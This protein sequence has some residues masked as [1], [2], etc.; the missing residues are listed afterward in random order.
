MRVAIVGGGVGGLTTCLALRA[1][2]IEA[3]V[4]EEVSQYKPVGAGILVAANGMQVLAQLGLAEAVEA[5]GFRVFRGHL[6]DPE[7][8]RICD[9][10]LPPNHSHSDRWRNVAIHRH[11]LM[12]VLSEALPAEAIQFGK[13]CVG[14]TDHDVAAEVRFAGGQCIEADL[15]VAADGL[16]SMQRSA[17]FPAATPR[18]AG[19]TSWRGYTDF[20]FREPILRDALLE[21]WGGDGTR[22]GFVPLLGGQTYWYAI[23]EASAREKDAPGATSDVLARTF[24]SYHPEILRLLAATPEPRVVRTDLYDL[25]RLPRW[26]AGRTVLLGDA[27]HGATPNLGQG[28]NQALEDAV[29]LAQALAAQ[30]ATTRALAMY[31]RRR[32][33]KAMFVIHFARFFGWVSHW[34][35]PW[36]TRLRNAVLRLN[37]F[38]IN[39]RLMTRLAR[40]S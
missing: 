10:L 37:L 38:R 16:R 15:V 39:Q 12:R 40:L 1:R 32:V 5:E 24:A 17:L 8:R 6:L 23:A 33:G 20:D 27:A 35:R 7:L 22:F 36:L 21:I 30:Q 29:V 4:Y 18:Y 19:Q 9:L 13:C 26:H 3:T 14:V 34:R 25:P 11:R 31:Y 2:G 28:G